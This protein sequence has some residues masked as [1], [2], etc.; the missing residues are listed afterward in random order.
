[1]AS[2][3]GEG[4]VQVMEAVGKVVNGAYR[5]PVSLRQVVQWQFVSSMGRVEEV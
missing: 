2:E 3:L 4:D 1:M 5:L